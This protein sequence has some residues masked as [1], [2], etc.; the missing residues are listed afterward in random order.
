MNG[1]RRMER[2]R[3]HQLMLVMTKM[4]TWVDGGW[5]QKREMRAEGLRALQHSCN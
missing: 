3:W 1:G 4:V 2:K 5:E